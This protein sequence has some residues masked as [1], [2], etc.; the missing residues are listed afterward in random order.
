MDT[1][2]LNANTTPPQSSQVSAETLING[3]PVTPVFSFA[4]SDP[5]VATVLS[6]GAQGGTV[7]AVKDTVPSTRTAD[8]IGTIIS[9]PG[10]G[11]SKT[12]VATVVTSEDDVQITLSF[13]APTPAAP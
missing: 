13:S 1:V 7:Q 12:A 9:G 8:I 5:T 6:D 3:L 11:K 2:T 4:S 10:T